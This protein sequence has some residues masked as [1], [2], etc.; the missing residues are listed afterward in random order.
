MRNDV[1]PSSQNRPGAERQTAPAFRSVAPLTPLAIVQGYDRIRRQ[2]LV[3]MMTLGVAGLSLILLP[4]VFFPTLD[5]VSLGALLIVLLGSSA[6]Y[7]LNRYQQVGIAG[8][9]LLG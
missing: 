3:R 8:Y 9:F 1:A 2:R 4:S 5:G 7:L 6:A